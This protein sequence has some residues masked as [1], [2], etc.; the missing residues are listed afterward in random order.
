MYIHTCAISL[1]R[2]V[3]FG[4]LTILTIIKCE[5]IKKEVKKLASLRKEIWNRIAFCDLAFSF[6]QMTRKFI[7]V[8]HIY[9]NL[10]QSI[11]L[12]VKEHFR[13]CYRS[14]R[15]PYS[16]EKPVVSN[17]VCKNA[18]ICLPLQGL[19]I[20]IRSGK[21]DIESKREGNVQALLSRSA[22]S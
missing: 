12:F 8:Q 19:W 13:A 4:Q 18:R 1:Y 9:C 21:Q 5:I 2:I 7:H 15:T 16:K 6:R 22:V 3:L 14:H 10:R 20:S 11:F 17:I